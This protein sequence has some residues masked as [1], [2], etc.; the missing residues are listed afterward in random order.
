M[1]P[2]ITATTSK[3]L[4]NSLL[5]PCSPIIFEV[6]FAPG[7]RHVVA[8]DFLIS[9]LPHLPLDRLRLVLV[10]FFCAPSLEEEVL[11]G[12]L[13]SRSGLVSELFSLRTFDILPLSM[14]L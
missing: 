7:S 6:D 5:E 12:V 3:P 11:L 14:D 2:I 4:A 9:H 10:V 13:V 1:A 8:N